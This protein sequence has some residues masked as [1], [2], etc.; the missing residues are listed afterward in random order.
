MAAALKDNAQKVPVN[1]SEILV[2]EDIADVDPP[3]KIGTRADFRYMFRMGKNQELK[4]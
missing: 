1:T 3:E 4:V 2:E